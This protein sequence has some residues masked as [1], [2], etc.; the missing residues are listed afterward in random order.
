MVVQEGVEACDDGNDDNLDGCL[1]SCQLPVSCK[2]IKDADVMAPDGVYAID[3]GNGP[4]DVYCDMTTDEG[5]W[6]LVARFANADDANWMAPSGAWWYTQTDAA[7]T[8]TSRSENADAYSPAFHQVVADEMK[9]TR[10]DNADDAHL[11]MTNGTCLNGKTFREHITGFGDFQNAAVWGSNEVLGTC[12]ASLGNNW[13]T[14]NGFAQGQCS[15]DIGAPNSISFWSDWSQ[16][17]GAVM[18]IG[19]GGNSCS[20]ADHGIG[21]TEANSASFQDG[22]GKD[23]FGNNGQN[24]SDNYALNLF[25]R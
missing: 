5:G 7:G 17:D 10:T 16:G 4:F 1:N 23:D 2:A 15:S 11:L 24:Y 25:V 14:T 9:L 21:V 18:M 19:G 12:V 20:R 8:P 3:V 6:T 22:I 13:N